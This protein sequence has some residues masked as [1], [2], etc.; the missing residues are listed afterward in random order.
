MTRD[1]HR[2]LVLLY[3]GAQRTHAIERAVAIG[4]SR[5]MAEFARTFGDSGQHGVTMRNGFV[6]GRFDTSGDVLGGLD[7]L[8]AHSEILAW[9]ET[10]PE[11]PA[12]F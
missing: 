8:F 12:A 1:A 2:V 7:G 6:T 5:E 9:C 4:G 11:K 3:F 10:Q